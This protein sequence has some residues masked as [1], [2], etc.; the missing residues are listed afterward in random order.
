MRSTSSGSIPAVRIARSEATAAID[1]VVSSAAATRRS[2]IPV[3]DTIHSSLVSTI[4]SRS[5]FVSTCAGA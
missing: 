2:R 4:R 1:A 3:R 5:L